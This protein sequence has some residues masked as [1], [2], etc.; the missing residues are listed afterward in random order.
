MQTYAHIPHIICTLTYHMHTH[1]HMHNAYKRVH[2]AYTCAHRSYFCITVSRLSVPRHYKPQE[3]CVAIN[4]QIIILEKHQTAL[5][6]MPD[7]TS[8]TDSKLH[9]VC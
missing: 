2:N 9:T 6:N 4:N 3:T 7:S 1:T 5:K 8:S